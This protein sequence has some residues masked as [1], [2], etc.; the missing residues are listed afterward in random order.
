MNYLADRRGDEFPEPH[1]EN[2]SLDD[3]DVFF[4][5]ACAFGIPALVVA[6]GA[7]AVFWDE[8]RGLL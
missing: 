2:E 1:M 6:I 7:V 3:D 4:I 5:F 8:I